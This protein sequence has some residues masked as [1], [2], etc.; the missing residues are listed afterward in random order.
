MICKRFEVVR[1][2]D[3]NKLSSKKKGKIRF[4]FKWVIKL[5]VQY[6]CNCYSLNIH[7]KTRYFQQKDKMCMLRV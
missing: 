3:Y 1:K 2:N 6:D 5:Y 4:A 7:M